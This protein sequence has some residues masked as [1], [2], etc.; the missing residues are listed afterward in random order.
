MKTTDLKDFAKSV[1]VLADQSRATGPRSPEGKLRA[2]LNAV[3][4]GLAAQ[5]LLLPGED[6][7]AYEERMDGVFAS[8]APMDDAQAQ[9][10]ALVGDDLWKLDRLARIEQGVVMGRIEELLATAAAETAQHLVSALV[11]LG[12]ALRRWESS[13]PTS[14]SSLRASVDAVHEAL[15]AVELLGHVITK[16]EVAECRERLDATRVEAADTHAAAFRAAAQLMAKLL[17]LGDQEAAKEEAKRKALAVIALPDEAEL[18]KRTRR[19]T[20]Q[21]VSRAW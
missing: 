5:N 11:A 18:K 6:P 12:G 4:H 21:T 7:A 16:D 1:K 20:R 8:L 14:P 13:P 9:L 15:D 17:A 3:K 2:S 19:T 10:V